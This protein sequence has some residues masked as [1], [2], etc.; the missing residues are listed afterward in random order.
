MT[1]LNVRDLMDLQLDLHSQIEG[2]NATFYHVPPW[3][4][5]DMRHHAALVYIYIYIFIGKKEFFAV[6]VCYNVMHLKCQVSYA[7][8]FLYTSKSP[9]GNALYFEKMLGGA[10]LVISGRRPA[11]VQR[12]ITYKCNTI[13]YLQ[14]KNER[15]STTTG[16]GFLPK[17]PNWFL[18]MHQAPFAWNDFFLARTSTIVPTFCE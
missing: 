12:Y 2:C 13:M 4:I 1:K 11:Q 7:T 9:K 18:P 16:T 8:T 17:Y 5:S 6:S 10:A 3:P 15:F 14:S